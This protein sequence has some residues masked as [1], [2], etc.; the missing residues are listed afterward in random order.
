MDIFLLCLLV[1]LGMQLSFFFIAYAFKFD[2]VTDFAG[3]MNF[4]VLALICLFYDDGLMPATTRERVIAAGVCVSRTELALILLGRVLKRGHDARF[5]EMREKFFSFLAFW[6]FQIMWV[7]TVSTTFM[8]LR[9]ARVADV[10]LDAR[11]YVGW[12]IFSFGF[13]VQLVSD[14]QK[15][16]FRAD[17][18]NKGKV[19]SSGLWSW[20][21]HPNYYGEMLIW[22]GVFISCCPVFAVST[23]GYATIASPIFTMLILLFL[24]GMPTAEGKNLAR[25][26]KTEESADAYR[27]YFDKTSPII[28]FPPALYSRMP[29]FIKKAFFFEY[30]MY[31]Y[32]EKVLP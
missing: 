16:R 10:P 12:A 18:R 13:L 25:F 20:S 29:P 30:D 26:F 14:A 15:M 11:D 8:Y 7:Y 31:K 17:P 27:E 21:R 19:C 5:D 6:V 1:T 4:T 32:R 28:L 3:G 2:K 24:S 23:A 22:W 9:H